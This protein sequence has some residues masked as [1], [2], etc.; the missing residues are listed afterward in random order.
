MSLLGLEEKGENHQPNDS[1]TPIKQSNSKVLWIVG[2]IAL[3]FLGRMIGDQIGR[4]KAYTERKEGESQVA[5]DNYRPNTQWKTYTLPET[6][7]SAE[8][9]S[10]PKQEQV[11]LELN[12]AE[13]ITSI[14]N[15]SVLYKNFVIAVGEM[16]YKEGQAT[17][18]Y[19][20][21]R[22]VAE[23][24]KQTMPSLIY[25]ISPTK[26]DKAAITGRYVSERRTYVLEGC[27]VNVPQTH[28]AYTVLVTYTTGDQSLSEA[29]NRVFKSA[30][31][32]DERICS[33]VN[34]SGITF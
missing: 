10:E 27:V 33:E 31:V 19:V 11:P 28:K 24:F 25:T 16:A 17:D 14:K 3:G 30:S 20:G 6:E 1:N 34:F 26:Q 18:V 22:G 9:P 21:A 4:F 13:K 7:L 29:A 5:T 15:F 32:T 8:L 2:I 23:K 12:H